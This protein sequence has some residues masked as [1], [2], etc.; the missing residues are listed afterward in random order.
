MPDSPAQVVRYP[1]G[2]ELVILRNRAAPVLA[3]DLWVRVGSASE[4]PGE[5]G[6]A[7]LV[8]H[9]L[10]KGTERREPGAIAREIEGVG[11][12][13]NAFTSFDH[14]VYTLVLASRFADL[15]LDILSDAVFHAGFDPGELEREKRVVLEEI[16]RGRDLPQLYLSRMLFSEAYRVHP[17]G[18]PV[19]GTEESV[20]SFTREHC[21]RFVGRWYRPGNMT[22]V[23]AGDVDPDPLAEAVERAFGRAGPRGRP[24]LPARPREPRPGAFRARFEARQVNE[25]YFNLAFPGPA[26]SH[27]DVPAV[28]LLVTIL[29][30]GESSRLQ[31]RVKLDRNLVRSVGAGAYTPRDPGLVYLGG[32]VDPDRADEA[33]RAIL[34]EV[35]RLRHEPVGV[36]ELERARQN[37]EADFVYQKETVQGQAQKAGFFHLVLGDTAAEERYL[38]QLHRVTAGEVR[39][40]A[41]RY[42][43]A[44]RGVL[45]AIHPAGG[46]LP[47]DPAGAG[48]IAVDLEAEGSRVHRR[49]GAARRG[50]VRRVLPNGARVLVKVNPGVPLVAVRAAC[51]GG[52][53][54]EPAEKAGAFHLLAGAWTRGTRSRTVFDIAHAIDALSGEVD[55]FSGRNSFG[56]K[57]EFLSR[58]LED[59]LDLVAEILCH[60]SFPEEEVA[61]VRDDALASIRLRRDNPAAHAF[62]LFEETLFGEHPF[63]RDVLGREETLRDLT[64]E[65]LRALYRA[66]FRPEHLAVAVVGDVEPDRVFEFLERALPDLAPAGDIPP[67]PGPPSPPDGP[68]VRREPAGTEQS[69]VVVGFLGTRVL[70][71]DRYALRVINAALS[72]QGGRLFRRLRDEMGLAYAVTSTCVEG[73]DPG[74][75]AGYIA[76]APANAEIAREGLL[77]EIT[78]VAE[79]PPEGA[80][81]EQAKRKL[82]GSFEIALQENQVQATQMALDEIYGLGYR[83]FGEFAR[84]VM[85]VTTREVVEASRRY[86]RAGT[87]ASVI[88][89]PEG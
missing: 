77:E 88:L 20:R 72:G 56:I 86:L 27:R 4:G 44:S 85:A 80:E 65:D 66:A 9:M 29:G 39:A 6:L 74:Y 34:H 59:G 22:L 67:E 71:P 18:R 70:D 55:G 83:S 5:A 8:E 75:L 57:A 87:C 54:Q 33:Y 82:V 11:G 52:L 48:R 45:V 31:H 58:F 53:R 2:F 35:F 41:R 51:R 79:A 1:N 50:L 14:T 47:W 89:G 25:T 13:I 19:I 36:R 30:Q 43:R 78:R 63:G 68:R 15:G 21:R 62:R 42:L 81:L 69:H 64:A 24:R 37:V 16:R 49:S 7:H 46:P 61:K 40:A 3:L 10:F 73:L 28:D 76:T 32:V 60:P 12:E 26:A 17:Y 84:R 23:V 38:E